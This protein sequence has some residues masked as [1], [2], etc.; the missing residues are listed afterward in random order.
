LPWIPLPTET[1]GVISESDEESESQKGKLKMKT[2]RRIMIM[3][4][5]TS[6]KSVGPWYLCLHVETVPFIS[7]P[8]INIK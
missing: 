3:A 4:G 1:E 5:K 6:L 7:V 2:S 8:S